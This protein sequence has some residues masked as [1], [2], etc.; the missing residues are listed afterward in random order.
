MALTDMQIGPFI[1]E[2]TKQNIDLH[3]TVSEFVFESA[4]PAARVGASL[5]TQA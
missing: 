5:D 2:P 1:F 3:P 4:L